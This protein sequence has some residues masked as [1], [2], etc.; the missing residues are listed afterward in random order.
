LL[1]KKGGV[2]KII[3][4]RLFQA[5]QSGNEYEEP[6]QKKTPWEDPRL[7]IGAIRREGKAISG[8]KRGLQRKLWLGRSNSERGDD[9]K[10][11]KKQKDG[12]EK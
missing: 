4:E 7:Y 9:C 8:R 3:G 5:K 2:F 11:V 10:N 12:E 6:G 1:G